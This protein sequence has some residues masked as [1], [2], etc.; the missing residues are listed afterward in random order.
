MS[1]SRVHR[2]EARLSWDEKADVQA[3]ALRRGL[4]LSALVR[5]LILSAIRQE[6]ERDSVVRATYPQGYDERY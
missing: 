4:T 3:L 1:G 5:G 2:V 6:L